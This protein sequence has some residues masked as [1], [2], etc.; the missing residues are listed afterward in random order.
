MLGVL[1]CCR[2]AVGKARDV[3]L[4]VGSTVVQTSVEG[5]WDGKIQQKAGSLS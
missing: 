5:N 3:S 2:L 1:S 4:S